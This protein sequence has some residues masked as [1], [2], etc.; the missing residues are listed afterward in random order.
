MPT[1]LILTGRRLIWS[2]REVPSRNIKGEVMSTESNLSNI[3]GGFTTASRG[4]GVAL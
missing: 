4:N 1:I 3:G 2:D